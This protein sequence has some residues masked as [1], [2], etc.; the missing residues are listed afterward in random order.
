MNKLSGLW[1][2]A[3]LAIGQLVY[4]AEGDCQPLPDAEGDVLVALISGSDANALLHIYFADDEVCTSQSGALKFDI[5]SSI[6]FHVSADLDELGVQGVV[7]G[8]ET[9]LRVDSKYSGELLLDR[10]TAE[11]LDLTAAEFLGDNSQLEAADFFIEYV[12]TFEIGEIAL[13]NVETNIPLLEAPY[14]HYIDRDSKPEMP[15][16][17]VE[18]LTVG[19]IGAAILEELVITLDIANHQM[20]MTEAR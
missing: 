5:T 3:G 20:T 19:S 15:A 16:P 14:D 2:S 8:F 17:E 9:W 1:L 7:E 6:N 10:A 11:G 13:R 12:G 4:A 18:F